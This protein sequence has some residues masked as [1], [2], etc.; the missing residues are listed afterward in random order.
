MVKA[1]IPQALRQPDNQ[2]WV[3]ILSHVTPCVSLSVIS[4]LIVLLYDVKH[5]GT[6][7]KKVLYTSTCQPIVVDAGILITPIGF[8]LEMLSSCPQHVETAEC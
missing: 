8:M 7:F 3:R 4:C 6:L 1:H 5:F 2:L